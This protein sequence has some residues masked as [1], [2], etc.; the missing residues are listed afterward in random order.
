LNQLSLKKDLSRFSWIFSFRF[1]TFDLNISTSSK[2]KMC[3]NF[4]SRLL[5]ANETVFIQKQQKKE[6][7]SYS[8]KNQNLR[9][10]VSAIFQ[11]ETSW[12]AAK[13][14]PKLSVQ[15]V[16]VLQNIHIFN[17]TYFFFGRKNQF[18]KWQKNPNRAYYP[19][20]FVHKLLMGKY[21]FSTLYLSALPATTSWP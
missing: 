7:H 10:T 2:R 9:E 6:R 11:L 17:Y 8:K 12:Q 5:N 1:Q 13:Q 4:A 18:L 19:F 3:H 20:T 21:H 14:N 15:A 16:K